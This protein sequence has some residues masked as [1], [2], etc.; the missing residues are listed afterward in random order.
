MKGLI[1][2]PILNNSIVHQSATTLKPLTGDVIT[3]DGY[4]G[5]QVNTQYLKLTCWKE[6]KWASIQ[7]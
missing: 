4:T 1:I 5:Q 6:E 2:H 3:G 7:I